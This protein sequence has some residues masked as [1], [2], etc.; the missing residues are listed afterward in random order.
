MACSY[1]RLG[2]FE[3]P[4]YISW[5]HQNR[6]QLIR[7]PAAQGEYR[8]I[9]VRSADPMCNPY[10]ALSLLLS[11][12]LEGI[13]DQLKLPA[14][15]NENLYQRDHDELE[16]LPENLQEAIELARGSEFVQK[17]LP[18]HLIDKYLAVKTLEFQHNR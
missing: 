3:A 10:L 18:Q 12:G 14:A 15:V 1:Q 4:K 8:R 16:K 6:S 11:A 5:S 17:V 13:H 7:I 9:E 2:H